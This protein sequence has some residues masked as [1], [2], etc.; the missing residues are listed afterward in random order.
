MLLTALAS[1]QL[2]HNRELSIGRRAFVLATIVAAVVRTFI[3]ER[4]SASGWV[5]VG[6]ALA[7]VLWSRFPRLRWPA[8][9]VVFA[10]TLAGILVPAVYEFAGGE[11]DWLRTGGSRIALIGRVL[12]V[13]KHSPLLGIGPAAYRAYAAVEPLRYRQ[14]LWRFPM[15]SSHNN[16]VDLYSQG[17]LV[18]LGLWAWGFVEIVRT[19]LRLSARELSPFARGYVA[20][21]LAAA[22][23]SAVIMVLA[24]WILPFVYNIGFAGFQA[25]VLVWLFWGGLAALEHWYGGAGEAATRTS[26]HRE[27]HRADAL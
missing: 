13:T 24:D 2:L 16:Y 12:D 8:A 18:A 19:G 22:A 17:G 23:G 10:M 14:T 11:A 26:D 27:S 3:L 25:S 7:G 21:A 1:A 9:V 20:G 5:G 4:E 15:V 6:V